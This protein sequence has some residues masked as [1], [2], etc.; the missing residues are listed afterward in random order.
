MEAW[1]ATYYYNTN[2]KAE[3][4]EYDEGQMDQMCWAS[5]TKF[6]QKNKCNV[7]YASDGY[8]Y[9]EFPTQS[10]CCQC[11]NSFGAVKYDWLQNSKY[12]GRETING[13]QAD[14]WVKDGNP[15]LGPMPN[16]YWATV[17][18]Q[19]PVR[20][21]ENST[22]QYKDIVYDL[23]TYK[24]GPLDNSLFAPPANCKT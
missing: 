14:H 19:L 22:S 7:I 18:E 13:T 2:L 3:R 20:F 16:N 5:G 8:I 24:K 1:T 21:Y 6:W 17:G 9:V 23:S 11:T 10:Y 15:N 12:V 4:Y